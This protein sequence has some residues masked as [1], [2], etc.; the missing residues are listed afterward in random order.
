VTHL[1][2]MMLE[3]LQRRHYSE[4]TTQRYIRFIERFAQHFH[5]SPDRL[6]RQ[7]PSVCP[8]LP[9]HPDA[10]ETLE[11]C[12]HS[13]SQEALSPAHHSQSGRSS[14]AHRCC[15]DSLLSHHFD[16]PLRHRRASHRDHAP[17]GQRHRQPTHGRA[18]SGR[19]R[20][21]RPRRDAQPHPARGT[22]RSL[23]THVCKV[24]R[25]RRHR[26][27]NI[28]ATPMWTFRRTPSRCARPSFQNHG[29]WCFIPRP[30]RPSRITRGPAIAT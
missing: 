8:A 27:V 5:C 22:A 6:G 30:Q 10:Q 14:T 2:K 18:H 1:R 24:G 7:Q 25:Q 16:D 4:A 11:H 13:L 21:A 29:S 28:D 19:Q 9:L 23:A 17:E 20:P 15:A 26:Y 12:R 3:E